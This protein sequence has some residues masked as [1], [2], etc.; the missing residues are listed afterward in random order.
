MPIDHSDF[1]IPRRS[2]STVDAPA[3]PSA[4]GHN[5][6]R[7]R[8]AAAAVAK[9]R[10]RKLRIPAAPTVGSEADLHYIDQRAASLPAYDKPMWTIGEVFRWVI[11]RT[12]QAVNGLSVDE[13]RVLEALPDVQDALV[14]G[15]V[16]ASG[17][18]QHDPIA[19]RL[20]PETFEVHPLTAELTNDVLRV[21]PLVPGAKVDEQAI[22]NVLINRSSVFQRW[23]APDD[24]E[25]AKSTIATENRTKAWLAGIM[26]AAPNVPRP[27]QQM[28]KEAVSLF[29]ISWQAFR[30]VWAAAIR[31]T[32]SHTWSKA[33]RRS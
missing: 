32:N 3:L 26:R 4:A 7:L 17:N 12:P 20:S 31:D 5:K 30:R 9:R 10:E 21:F 24:R 11:E 18:T 16:E 29:G 25:A 8:V 1:M 27:K 6:R 14:C 33:G 28:F 23:P 13:D 15:E 2:H 22:F 19:R